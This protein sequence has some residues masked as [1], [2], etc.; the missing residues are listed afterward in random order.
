MRNI[1]RD[2]VDIDLPRDVGAFDKIKCGL[3]HGTRIYWYYKE[4]LN[5][6]PD[7]EKENVRDYEYFSGIVVYVDGAEIRS[8]D[9]ELDYEECVV[10]IDT[11]PTEKCYPECAWVALNRLIDDD[12]LVE[13]YMKS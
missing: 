4:D 3:R 13:I 5:C 2:C 11:E 6:L 7:E 9:S 10:V 8:R 1:K 12:N